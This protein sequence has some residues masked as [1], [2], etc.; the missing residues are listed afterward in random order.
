MLEAVG[1]VVRME[2]EEGRREGK[3]REISK[4]RELKL[5]ENKA[6]GGDGIPNEAWKCGGERTL[7]MAW[8]ICERVWRGERWPKGWKEGLIVPIVKKGDGRTV[9][10]YR[11]VTLMPSLYKVYTTK[12]A[13]RLVE[14]VEE[15]GMISQ[16]QTGLRKG[17]ETVDNVYVLNYLV[18]K[19]MAK[20]QGKLVAM[21]VDLRATFDLV[22][23]RVILRALEKRGVRKGL[24]EKVEDVYRE[25]IGMVKV[26]EETGKAFR[27]GKGVRQGCPLSPIVFNI[28]TADLEEELMKGSSGGVKLRGKRVCSLAEREEETESIMRR[29]ERYFEVKKLQVNVGKTKIMRF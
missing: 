4:L 27:I 14:E 10:E 3:E 9:E 22:D 5:R 23:R 25:T 2:T 11:G 8:E 17:L 12:L 28:L 19:R 16:N 24:R 29:L 21:F 13:R 26:V 20:K 18:N 15:K 1:E 7:E 6:M